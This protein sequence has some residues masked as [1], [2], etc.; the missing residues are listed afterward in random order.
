MQYKRS[1]TNP[2]LSLKTKQT[3][4]HHLTDQTFASRLHLYAIKV[5]G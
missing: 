2:I 1:L 3:V 5:S 4:E